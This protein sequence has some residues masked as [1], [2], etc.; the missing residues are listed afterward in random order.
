MGIFLLILLVMAYIFAMNLLFQKKLN[1]QLGN[2]GEEYQDIFFVILDS[3]ILKVRNLRKRV[4]S[5]IPYEYAVRMF[6]NKKA[7]SDCHSTISIWLE[8]DGKL[9][10]VDV[11]IPPGITVYGYARVVT[12]GKNNEKLQAET[13]ERESRAGSTLRADAPHHRLSGGNLGS[14][15]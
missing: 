14:L 2:D 10:K 15:Q 5:S 4:Q 7:A 9:K 1:S 13:G 11:L 3:V 6:Q 12:G 8:E